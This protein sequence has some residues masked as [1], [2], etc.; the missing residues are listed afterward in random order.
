M[1]FGVHSCGGAL[2]LQ[3]FSRLPLKT[4]SFESVVAAGAARTRM[5]V[6]VR[7]AVVM[8]VKWCIFAEINDEGERRKHGGG[9]REGLYRLL[10]VQV[11]KSGGERGRNQLLYG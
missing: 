1:A 10:F 4:A 8:R 7:R 9:W 5:E 2:R 11:C 6:D 3:R